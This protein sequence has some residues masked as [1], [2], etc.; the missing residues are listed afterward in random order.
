MKEKRKRKEKEIN[1]KLKSCHKITEFFKKKQGC[2]NKPSA[3][4]PSSKHD[5][6][7]EMADP[8]AEMDM[9]WEYTDILTPEQITRLNDMKEKTFRIRRH[10]HQQRLFKEELSKKQEEES[11]IPLFRTWVW[12]NLDRTPT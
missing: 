7:V 3:T 11:N 10:K 2:G 4:P 12:R 6:D 8:D 1:I 9:D 5:S